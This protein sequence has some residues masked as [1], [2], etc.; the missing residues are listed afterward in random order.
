M[1]YLASPYTS[2]LKG[3]LKLSLQQERA[4]QAL[5]F[6]AMMMQQGF[7]LFSP[8]VY[9][10]SIASVAGLPTDAEFWWQFNIDYLRH[11]EAIFVLR[12]PGWDQSKGVQAEIR[13]AKLMGLGRQDF[14][15]DFKQVQ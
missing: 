8:V 11:A 4:N 1:I 10:H 2:D 9:G 13:Q 15:P 6:T 12:L 7:V 3:Q 14:G 5:A